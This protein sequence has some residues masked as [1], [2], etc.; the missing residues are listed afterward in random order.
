MNSADFQAETPYARFGDIAIDAPVDVRRS[1]I[2]KTYVNLMF[3]I[4]AFVALEWV[5]FSLGWEVRALQLI[6]NTPYSWLL[7]LGAFF[8]VSMVAN[9]WAISGAS[10]AMQYAGLYLYVVGEALIFLPLLALAKSQT[11]NVDGVGNVG[12]IPA[13][14]I[15]TLIIFG[16]L[17]AFTLISKQDFSF[18]GRFLGLATISAIALL[19]IS[20][21]FHPNMYIWFAW[22]MVVL[23]SGYILY[24]TSNVLHTYR[25]DQ[26]VA[27]ALALFASVALLF[28]YV[29]QIFMRRD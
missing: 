10:P 26:H 5:F 12:V 23:A 29:I 3:A 1:F 24:Y 4:Y 20:F 2:R 22:L 17:T 6:S 18:L 9:R 11:V 25:T 21:F 27:A 19:A 28:W 13:A 15:T 8:I 16:G 14:G 7:V